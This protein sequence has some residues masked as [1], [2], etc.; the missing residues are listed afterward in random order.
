VRAD[1]QLGIFP[2]RGFCLL[3]LLALAQDN[4]LTRAQIAAQ[5]WDN[6]GTA[7]NL[8]NLRQ[9]LLR[10]HRASPAFD[11]LVGV[12]AGTVWLTDQRDRI[13]LCRFLSLAA[14]REPSVTEVLQ[15]Y[16]GDLLQGV[17]SIAW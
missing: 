3:A 7:A 1:Q 17:P 10:M 13:D 11:T 8:R 12:D 9:L 15:L 4:R 14:E 5:L 6:D 2:L 16:R